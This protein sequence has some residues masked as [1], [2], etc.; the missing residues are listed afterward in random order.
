MSNFF[1]FGPQSAG[2]GG[3]GGVTSVNGQT[4]VVVL[5]APD[6]GGLTAGSVV[7]ADSGGFL[8]EDNANFFWDDTNNILALG[9]HTDP[10]QNAG[11]QIIRS[12]TDGNVYGIYNDV[13]LA[14]T[15]SSADVA[16]G[17]QSYIHTDIPTGMSLSGG[18]IGNAVT[19]SRAE[20]TD[21]GT[22]D[23]AAGFF[24]QLVQ[25]N[26]AKST[27]QYA[28]Y[29]TGFH[30]IDN[31]GTIGQLTD[32]LAISSSIPAGVVTDRFGI[33]IEPDSNY[34]KKNWISG[35]LLLGDTSYSTP[36]TVLGVVGDQLTI[37]Q[38]FDGNAVA[39]EFH[40]LTA[41]TVDGSNNTTALQGFAQA[42]VQAGATND[43]DVVGLVNTVQRGD[44]TDD[45]SL[46]TMSGVTS[47]LF[48]DS[49]L[50]GVTDK[51]YAYASILI[52]QQGQLT[53]H[54]DFY[55]QRAPAGGTLINH[56]GLYLSHD[57]TTPIQSWMSGTTVFGGT[58]YS[59]PLGDGSVYFDN[60]KAIKLPV[61]D[62]ATRDALVP[63][64]GFAIYNM[65]DDALETWDGST[66]SLPSA[67]RALSNLSTTALNTALNFAVGVSGLLLG[68]S[69]TN[70]T[71]ITIQTGNGTAGNSGDINVLTGGAT[72]IKGAINLGA[73]IVNVQ[74]DLAITTPGS[75]LQIA[76]G[77]KIGQATLSLGT[78]TV[79]NAA[80]TTNSM[81]IMS[82]S[83]PSGVQ[84]FLSFAINAGVDFTINS[85]SALDNSTIDWLIV[86]RI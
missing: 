62:T 43:K 81:V 59:T 1:V 55:S 27:G 80:V 68:A 46:A 36:P 70:S 79:S 65:D 26:G 30:S 31:Q 19:L 41:T 83:S 49:G 15:A 77:D 8:N 2:G 75:G 51:S 45:G 44:G 25:G 64:E 84:G 9:D 22:V 52:T 33:R 72:G 13:T 21:L 4:G 66:W 24:S 48:H 60:T 3:G 58:G 6:I 76:T 50:L 12:Y 23:I 17:M 14:L 38:L 37:K 32:F 11:I 35:Q 20:G 82:V 29:M 74:S 57:S 71:N 7:F 69:D 53:D 63:V 85:T 18:L 5:T 78:V 34:V 61:M 16:I 67:N 10:I 73:R 47:L 54:Y 42:V 86:E 39:G 56:Y 28:G 40:A